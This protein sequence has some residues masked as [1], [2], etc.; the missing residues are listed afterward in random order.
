MKGLATVFDNLD[1]FDNSEYERRH[2]CGPAGEI[3]LSGI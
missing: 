3:F 2:D 1:H